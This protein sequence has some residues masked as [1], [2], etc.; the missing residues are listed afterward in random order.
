M[1]RFQVEAKEKEEFA[2]PEGSGAKLRDIPNIAFKLGKLTGA[3]AGRIPAAG[4]SA[5]PRCRYISCSFQF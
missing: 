3:Q 5:L 1:E 2:I 4:A